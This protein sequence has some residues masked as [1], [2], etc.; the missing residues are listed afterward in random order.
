MSHAF[1][2]VTPDQENHGKKP[3]RQKAWPITLS[4][5]QKS[6]LRLVTH[7]AVVGFHFLDSQSLVRFRGKNEV[8][9]LLKTG[10]VLSFPKAV[11]GGQRHLPR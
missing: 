3:C 10:I 8:R 9:E 1:R 2:S 6:Q 11:I 7:K 5:T 4:Y